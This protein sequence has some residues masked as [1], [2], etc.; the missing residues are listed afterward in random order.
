MLAIGNWY[1][2]LCHESLWIRPS[3]AA[4][5]LCIVVLAHGSV[6][7]FL[8]EF[9]W[10]TQVEKV[11]SF[12]L[13]LQILLLYALLVVC[14]LESWLTKQNKENKTTTKKQQRYKKPQ[15]NKSIENPITC[16]IPINQIYQIFS[17][18][19]LLFALVSWDCCNKMLQ[20]RWLEITEIYCFIVLKARSLKLRCQK[21]NI[22]FWSLREHLFH[23]LLLASGVA[24]HPWLALA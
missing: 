2:C 11:S 14:Y 20:T 5:I 7:Y 10:P 13:P 6:Y 18:S 21:G 23:A 19:T 24:G 17:S 12:S 15:K 9:L 3:S 22:F 4:L 1:I 16:C 8:S